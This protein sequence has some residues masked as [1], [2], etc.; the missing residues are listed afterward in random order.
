MDD[1]IAG[2]P[3]RLNESNARSV[4]VEI[5]EETIAVLVPKPL[6]LA[7][8][9]ATVF[10]LPGSEVLGGSSILRRVCVRREASATR[11]M[12]LRNRL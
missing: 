12:F 3:H 4:G 7:V 8:A 5:D 1:L 6:E 10:L 9:A 11:A 2:L